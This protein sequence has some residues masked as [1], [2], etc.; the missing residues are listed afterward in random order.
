MP[1]P[2]PARDMNVNKDHNLCMKIMGIHA[3]ET[4][5]SPTSVVRRMVDFS[6]PMNFPD[7]YE[8]SAIFA[9]GIAKNNPFLIDS[10]SN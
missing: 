5:K 6:F 7:K 1:I 10:L 2:S 8:A 3:A 4:N 9:K